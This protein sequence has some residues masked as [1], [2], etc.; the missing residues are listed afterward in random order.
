MEKEVKRLQEL[1]GLLSEDE[2]VLIPR[3][4]PEE[5]G[6]NFNV[7]TNKKI[8]Q[9]IKDGSQGDLDLSNTLITSLPSELRTIGGSLFL[10][11]SKITSLPAGL[12]IGRHLALGNTKI[13]SLPSDLQVGGN[14]YTSPS[15]SKCTDEQFKQIANSVKG[16]IFK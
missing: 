6:R 16:Y 10:Q 4:S 3:R 14:L 8:Q 9:Y 2:K 15:L 11:N 12:T 1:A 5:R 13:T 7:A